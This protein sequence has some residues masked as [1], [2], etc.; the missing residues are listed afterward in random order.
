VKSEPKKRAKPAATTTQI[1]QNGN[2]V[3]KE[4][5]VSLVPRK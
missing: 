5:Q 4:D 1:H 2:D 3:K